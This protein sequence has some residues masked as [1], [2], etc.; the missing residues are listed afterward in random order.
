[1]IE[2]VFFLSIGAVAV[3]SP[4][5]TLLLVGIVGKE[6]LRP[7]VRSGRDPKTERA[8]VTRALYRSVVELEETLIEAFARPVD[9]A[10]AAML[11][12]ADGAA[13]A[14]LP[15]MNLTLLA[16]IFGTVRSVFERNLLAEAAQAVQGKL[17]LMCQAYL[18]AVQPQASVQKS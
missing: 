12:S 11:A 6:V 13:F 14:D 3:S 5:T 2:H 8:E 17:V 1:V 18:Q 10:T 16:T 9:A 4:A 7:L 15:T